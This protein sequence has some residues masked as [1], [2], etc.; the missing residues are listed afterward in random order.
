MRVQ[1]PQSGVVDTPIAVLG[2]PSS[3]ST[4]SFPLPHALVRVTHRKR[5]SEGMRSERAGNG[6][7]K[8]PGEGVVERRGKSMWERTNLRL[9]V[10]W[11]VCD[12]TFPLCL[13][14][15]LKYHPHHVLTLNSFYSVLWEFMASAPHS[16]PPDCTVLFT[17]TCIIQHTLHKCIIQMSDD[18]LC[19][20]A[21]VSEACKWFTTKTTSLCFN[22]LQNPCP[23]KDASFLSK[24][25]FW[26][27]T[28]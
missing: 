6:E 25:L 13:L 5:G 28:G 27:F 8:H 16:V 17:H 14:Q 10:C 26:W 7:S 15:T 4:T 9:C 18:C 3:S 20:T 21:H 22:P 12:D 24:I 11:I 23:V 2:V 19:E 1:K